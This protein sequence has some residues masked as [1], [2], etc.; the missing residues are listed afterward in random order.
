MH[1]S[2]PWHQLSELCLYDLVISLTQELKF[3]SEND[4]H[5]LD[6]VPK[7]VDVSK[8]DFVFEV[9]ESNICIFP[10]VLAHVPNEPDFHLLSMI[11]LFFLFFLFHP[12]W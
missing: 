2:S 12:A 11:N 6:A 4:V 5:I 7:S 9:I 10:L 8:Y 1:I 3:D